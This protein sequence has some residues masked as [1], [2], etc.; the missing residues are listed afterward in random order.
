MLIAESLEMA[1]ETIKLIRS[2]LNPKPAGMLIQEI[3]T[4]YKELT[5]EPVPFAKF[6]FASLQDFLRA[7]NQF[8]GVKTP[9]GFKLTAKVTEASKHVQDLA[10]TQTVSK[11]ERKRRQQMLTGTVGTLK[12]SQS[13]TRIMANIPQMPKKYGAAPN[14]AMRRRN[15]LTRLAPSRTRPNVTPSTARP[16]PVPTRVNTNIAPPQPIFKPSPTACAPINRSSNEPK[17]AE[18]TSAKVSPPQSARKRLK[19]FAAASST[20]NVDLAKKLSQNP[21]SAPHKESQQS[22]N[23][24]ESVGARKPA[25]SPSHT[26]LTTPNKVFPANSTQDDRQRMDLHSCFVPKQMPFTEEPEVEEKAASSPGFTSSGR[27]LLFKKIVQLK[28]ASES[29][30][31]NEQ[32]SQ[33]QVKDE[34]PANANK[35]ND[36][37]SEPKRA[38]VSDFNEINQKV[39]VYSLHFD[40][41]HLLSL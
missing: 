10:R 21:V 19:N 27:A 14:Q 40:F 31:N 35:G 22:P 30:A 12:R 7:S 29:A 15:S 41:I 37:N 4:E 11:Q 25:K 33:Q 24:P 26:P 6:N 9:H 3:N 18:Q 13:K 17:V 34:R 1:E 32:P 8:N 28:K 36:A 38:K 39:I 5:G 23:E 16:N 20:L 2:I